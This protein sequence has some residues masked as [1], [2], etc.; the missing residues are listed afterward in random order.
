MICDGVGGDNNATEYDDYGGDSVV[1][2]AC[3]F[4]AGDYK[5]QHYRQQ[6]KITRH[7]WCKTR[8]I[9]CRVLAALAIF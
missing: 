9:V 5:H 6:C 8:P 7:V 2:D 4:D 1:A 3:D